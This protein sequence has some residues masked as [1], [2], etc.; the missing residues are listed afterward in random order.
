M[1]SPPT[2]QL[3]IPTSWDEFENI[4]ADVLK[5]R[6]KTPHV[7]RNGRSGQAQNGVDIFALARHCAAPGYAGAQCKRTEALA[8]TT[9]AESV[10]EAETFVPA[11]GE[12]LIC[13][14]A[15]RDA[16]LQEQA[17]ALNLDRV[18]KGLFSVEVLFWEDLSL[19]L[20]GDRAL[21]AKH[22]PDW[23]KLA[24]NQRQPSLSL[25]WL[26]GEDE[27]E[28]LGVPRCPAGLYRLDAVHYPFPDSD[29][30][31]DEEKAEVARYNAAL[32]NLLSDPECRVKWHEHHRRGRFQN[33]GK[34][35]GLALSCDGAPATDILCTL[36]FPKPFEVYEADEPPASAPAPSLPERPL[37]GVARRLQRMTTFVNP[38]AG[39]SWLR[40]MDFAPA[41]VLSLKAGFPRHALSVNLIGPTL[42]VKGREVTLR[43]ARLGPRRTF[44]F[45]GN[46]GLVVVA[47]STTGE[48]AVSWE[49]DC[50]L[51]D[52]PIQ[53]ELKLRVD[54]E[55][56]E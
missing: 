13:T 31:D 1:P 2:T 39:A 10:M 12:Y 37:V 48:Y 45:D 40:A 54:F 35:C 14:T 42:S 43:A 23:S 51:L 21:L 6:W 36:T 7:T 41:Q 20:S 4:V 22:F 26:D 16:R 47:P 28:C 15:S 50:E 34:R 38:F 52:A 49:A 29:D 56:K 17:R 5:A 53:G 24:D 9:V 30:Y 33:H 18:Q 55:P 32:A 19:D 3:P 8:W 27:V 11:L 46:R 25:R 44:T